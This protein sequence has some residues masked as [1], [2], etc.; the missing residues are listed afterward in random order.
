MS[1]ATL[2]RPKAK[3]RWTYDEFA[4]ESPESNLPTE[5]WDGELIMS[6]APRPSHQQVVALFWQ[7]LNGFVSSHQLGK[8]FISPCD[9]VLTQS[10]VVQPDIIYI[11]RA[12]QG[13]IRNQIR[14]VPDLVV[15]VISE[16]SW[17]R[18]RL[19]KKALYEQ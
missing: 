7:A 17:R 19:D 4:A 9:V 1:T 15:E 2:P 14:G 10:R 11:S 13:I 8:V 18:D 12:R 3:R 6:P 5:L 16:G